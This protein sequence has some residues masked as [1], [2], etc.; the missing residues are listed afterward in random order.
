M[1]KITKNCKFIGTNDAFK[2]LQG[3][4]DEEFILINIA[5]SVHNFT[6]KGV[7]YLFDI[8]GSIFTREDTIILTGFLSDN[9]KQV[10]KIAVELFN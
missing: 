9:T 8:K 5:D 4:E 10:G 3:Q 1:G 7:D 2:D 6:F